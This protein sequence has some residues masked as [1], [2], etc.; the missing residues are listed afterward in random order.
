MAEHPCG[1]CRFYQDS[2]WQPLPMAS[3]SLLS[4]GFVRREL[5]AGETLYHQGSGCRSVYCVSGGLFAIRSIGPDGTSSLMRLAYPGEII[6]YRAFLKGGEHSTEASALMPSRVCT[7]AER[8]ARHVIR[9]S[10]AVLERIAKRCAD[11]LDQCREQLMSKET[12]SNKD[13][14]FDLLN[15]LMSAFGEEAG[16]GRRVRLPMSRQDLADLIGVAPETL[17]RLL[18]RL[19]REGALRASGRRIEMP[20]DP[21][22]RAAQR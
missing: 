8:D 6:G 19:E 3:A 7:V 14:L 16:G 1:T 22:Q 12:V 13:R 5:A 17:S 10:P 11:G 9:A 2:I 15:R 21:A 18:S 4:K 20:A